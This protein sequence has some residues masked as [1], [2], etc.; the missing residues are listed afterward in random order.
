MVEGSLLTERQ[1]HDLHLAIAQYL[2]PL[3]SSEE[4][5]FT[6]PRVLQ[7]LEIDESATS[8][9]PNYLERKWL[10][11][12]KLQKKILDLETQLKVAN[13]TIESLS[14]NPSSDAGPTLD[15]LN[16]IPSKV[17]RVIKYHT[18]PVTAL[19]IHPYK[20]LLATGSSDGSIVLWDLLDLAQPVSI[21]RNAHSRGVSSLC[22]SPTDIH[23]GDD[24]TSNKLVV[25]AS[26]SL[27]MFIK[28]WDPESNFTQLRSLVGHENMVSSI[29]FNPNIP[30]ELI[31]CS[32]DTSIRLWDV[33]SGFCMLT[34]V[35]HSDWVR[36][37]DVSESGEYVLSCSNDQSIRISHKS[38]GSGIGL[39]LGHNQVIETAKFVPAL[40]NKYLDDICAKVLQI[41]P[42]S[43]FLSNP[44]F[45]K[46]GYKYA[47]SGG[48]D[49]TVR[50]WLLPLPVFKPGVDSPLP[51]STP[52]GLLI[53][54]LEGHSSWVKD[55]QFHPNATVFASCSDDATIKFWDPKKIAGSIE[56]VSVLKGHHGFVN[57]IAFAPLPSDSDISEAKMRCYFVSGSSD[58]ITQLWS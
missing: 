20:P 43:E 37:V 25:L 11:I 35:G 28:V 58:N 45:E 10:T 30:S 57:S 34:F 50:I 55:I 48:R 8:E 14:Q 22:F 4:D 44:Q 12:L 17:D 23:M 26:A 15:R 54:T 7:R 49:N 32:K 27:D 33:S 36:D 47:I 40:A 46:V 18:Q 51:S 13:E 31:S 19:A 41:D 39:L 9:N 53:A 24:N 1:R 56:C 6:L 52:E 42:S 38:T 16:W 21:A 5:R 29:T 2:T 3:L